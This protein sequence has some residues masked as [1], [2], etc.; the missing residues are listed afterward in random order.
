MVS[1]P[2]TCQFCGAKLMHYGTC[3][4]T[5][6]TLDKIDSE[7]EEIKK[8]LIELAAEEK[9]LLKGTLVDLGQIRGD[10]PTI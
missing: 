9:R 5:N 1:L 7:R 3:N 6:A 2:R 4:C 8:R 10:D